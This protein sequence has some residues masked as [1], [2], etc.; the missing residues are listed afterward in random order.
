M[1]PAQNTSFHSHSSGKNSPPAPEM[2][3]QRVHNDVSPVLAQTFTEQFTV[4]SAKRFPGVP[5]TWGF[6]IIVAIDYGGL[7]ILINNQ[8][9]LFPFVSSATQIPPHCLSHLATKAK[10]FLWYACFLSCF[11]S[12]ANPTLLPSDSEIGM[13][14]ASAD[15]GAIPSRTR[16][17][18]RHNS[19]SHCGMYGPSTHPSHVY[20][21]YAFVSSLFRPLY[22]TCPVLCCYISLNAVYRRRLRR[23]QLIIFSDTRCTSS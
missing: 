22:I 21:M 1:P 12:S 14:R 18:T 15:G 13:A 7:C 10:S 5:G 16:I 3:S 17:R 20:F 8:P 2:G 11:V 23:S 6:R 4:F 19:P 9:F